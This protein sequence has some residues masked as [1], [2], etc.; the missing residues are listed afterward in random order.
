MASPGFSRR[1]ALLAFFVAAA[2]A[3]STLAAAQPLP[4]KEAA[5][6]RRLRILVTPLAG[7][8]SH[9]MVVGRLAGELGARGHAD[10]TLLLP[11]PVAPFLRKV[12]PASPTLTHLPFA[13]STSAA[14]LARFVAAMQNGAKKPSLLD[15]RSRVG[16]MGRMAAFN[17]AFGLSCVDVVANAT[18]LAALGARGPFDLVIGDRM[19]A[20]PVALVTVL[21]G[22]LPGP[23]RVP[24]VNVHVGT[25]TDPWFDG[26]GAAYPASS[27][28]SMNWPVWGGGGAAGGHPRPPGSLAW[29]V[30]NA[31]DL[32]LQRALLRFEVDRAGPASRAAIGVADPPGGRAAIAP[33]LTIINS[34]WALDWPRAVPP[35]V[36]VPGAFLPGPTPPGFKLEAGLAGWLEE[37]APGAAGPTLYA[38]T[39]SFFSHT[40]EY[41][42][43]LVDSLLAALAPVDGRLIIKLSEAEM[44]DAAVAALPPSRVRVLRWAPQNEL[45]ATGGIALFLSHGGASSTYE[46]L[47]HGVPLVVMPCSAEQPANAA[48]VAASGAGLTLPQRPP[49]GDVAAAVTAALAGL[50]S[51]AAGARAASL[52]MRAGRRPPAAVAAEAVE[53]LGALVAAGVDPAYLRPAAALDTPWVVRSGADVAAVLVSGMGAVLALTVAGVRGAA[54]AVKG[55][56]GGGGGGRRPAARVS[57]S[58]KRR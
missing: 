32:A 16:P 56:G 43:S 40:P 49:V 25:A 8:A 28:S 55:G 23:A 33:I 36:L 45:L 42:A 44:G 5:G 57:A 13:A 52:R 4:V 41:S 14:K 17:A 31:L 3:T 37:R 26:E 47:Y 21:S 27:T 12:A 53:H 24:L 1:A 39:G 34:D 54:R 50:P 22:D 35:S 29:R 6:G 51:L 11:S 46:A 2:L 18:L 30:T 38:A 9:A 48:R 10:V 19:D 20:C 7:G 15:W 58:R